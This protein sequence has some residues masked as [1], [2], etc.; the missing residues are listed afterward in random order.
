MA[1][2]HRGRSDPA[3]ARISNERLPTAISAPTLASACAASRHGTL[4][5][6]PA[7][8]P[9]PIL[10]GLGAF[11]AACVGMLSLLR[12]AKETALAA[13]LLLS[14]LTLAALPGLWLAKREIASE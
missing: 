4:D 5:R 1:T 14:G 13:T 3:A 11:E 6:P 12:V 7:A 2:L 8:T 10:L 9:G